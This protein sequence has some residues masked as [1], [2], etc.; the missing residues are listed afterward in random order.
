MTDRYKAKDDNKYDETK[1]ELCTMDD[2]GICRYKSEANSTVYLSHVMIVDEEIIEQDKL[3]FKL[4]RQFESP[5]DI[6]IM[7]AD[8][9]QIETIKANSLTETSK[10]TANVHHLIDFRC[11]MLNSESEAT[12]I[13]CILY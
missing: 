1:L 11:E 4:M 9:K 8:N 13:L 6:L 7:L 5:D 3:A 10:I 12:R 2:D